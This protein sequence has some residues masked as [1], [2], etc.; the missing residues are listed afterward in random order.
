MKKYILLGIAA[1]AALLLA[2]FGSDLLGLYRLQSYITAS[3][4]TY[5]ADGG[6]WPHLTDVCIMCHGVKGNSLNQGYP[7]LA[8]QPAPYLETQLHNFASEARRSPNMGPLAMTLSDTQL[9]SVADYFSRQTPVANRYF[10]PDQQLREKGRQLAAAGNCA[11]CHGAH[12]MGHDQFPRLAGQG[13]DYLLAQFDEFASGTRSEPTGMMKSIAT[14]T[15][16]EDLKAIA[17]YLASLDPQK[18]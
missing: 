4:A 3:A 13:Y 5:R 7:S 8:G 11:A 12:L 17:S 9:K 16:P 10:K 15:S 14:R 18:N 6:P 2:V 1:I